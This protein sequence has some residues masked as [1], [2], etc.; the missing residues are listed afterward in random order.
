MEQK[1]L[2]QQLEKLAIGIQPINLFELLENP[3]NFSDLIEEMNSVADF[4]NLEEL[5]DSM[6]CLEAE[7]LKLVALRAAKVRWKVILRECNLHCERT[8][9]RDKHKKVLSK[10]CYHRIQL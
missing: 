6:H 7:E 8:T 2:I 1:L 9:A 10:I 4:M 5:L 3:T